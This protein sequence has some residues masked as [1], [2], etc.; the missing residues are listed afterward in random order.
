MDFFINGRRLT[1]KGRYLDKNGLEAEGD[2]RHLD[3]GTGWNANYNN[4]FDVDVSAF[5]EPGK[6]NTFAILTRDMNQ[7]GGVFKN[8][9][10]YVPNEPVNVTCYAP[11]V[12]RDLNGLKTRARCNCKEGHNF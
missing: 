2:I 8:V 12:V 10:L 6:V 7:R 1:W 9:F 3:L 5:L 11:H 4:Q